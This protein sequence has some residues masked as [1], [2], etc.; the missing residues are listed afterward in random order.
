M[1]V[2]SDRTT[3]GGKG[4]NVARVVKL[5]GAKVQATGLV[6]GH[7]GEHL[8]ELL[9]QDKIPHQFVGV[10]GETRCCIN[11][12]DEVNGSTEYLEPGCEV[13]PEEEQRFL[14]VFPEI[15]AGSN[16]ITISGSL[17]RGIHTD[18]YAKMVTMAKEAGKIVLLD[19]SGEA[20]R[21][22]LKSAPTLIKP[23]QDEIQQLFGTE[24]RNIQDTILYA[25]K[26]RECGIPYVV[27]SLGGDG[28]LLV[29]EEG[30]FLGKPPKVRVINTVG[31]GDSMI[32]AFATAFTWGYQPEEAL[33]YAVGVATANAMTPNTGDFDPTV[34]EGLVEQVVVR[35]L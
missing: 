10:K 7:N 1:R 35:K 6:G 9:D 31:C 28:A 17:P 24:I 26:L 33:R 34:L 8:K 29:C 2:A 16:V 12:L 22:A 30:I 13:S 15:I 11:I 20:L 21:Q 32:G 19:T 3:A 14:D 25:K 5:C 18:I 27:V 4:L 23:N